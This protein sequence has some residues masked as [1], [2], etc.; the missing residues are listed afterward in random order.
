M[1]RVV[2]SEIKLKRIKMIRT[3]VTTHVGN[4]RKNNE[5]NYFST[6]NSYGHQ[7]VCV[8]DGMGGHNAGE[9]ASKITCD[10]IKDDFLNISSPDISYT[11]FLQASI[12]KA[13]ALIYQKSLMNSEYANMGTTASI[14][15][16]AKGVAY[17]GH[18]GDSRIYNINSKGIV[19]LTKDHTL[20]QMMLDA[21][22][23]TAEQA[24]S[25]KV[26]NVVTQA[27]GT[28]AK[29]TIDLME[30]KLPKRYCF[31]LC[32]DGLTESLTDD[33]IFEIVSKYED[34]EA[35]EI[36][37]QLVNY[38]LDLGGSDN[39]TVGLVQKGNINGN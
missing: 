11:D 7:I 1:E 10:T 38:A 37:T 36:T 35:E 12:Q 32:S 34:Q 25:S 30:V 17:I 15:I 16:I 18:V 2:N 5:D 39:V 29:L 23:I 33:Q 4:V 6:E 26:R 19:Q 9:V 27:I 24:S 22:N 8:A 14:L 20:V 28:S 13:N 31:I 3:S 21:G